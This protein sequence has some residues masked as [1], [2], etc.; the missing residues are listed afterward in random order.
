MESMKKNPVSD[1]DIRGI[2]MESG[3]YVTQFMNGADRALIQYLLSLLVN[4]TKNFV[5]MTIKTQQWTQ[6]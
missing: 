6:P 2:K 1:K 5:W 4:E 3:D